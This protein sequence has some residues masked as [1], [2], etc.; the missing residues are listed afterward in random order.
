ME[1]DRPL[2]NIDPRSSNP[3]GEKKGNGNQQIEANRNLPNLITSLSEVVKVA[4]H[5][6]PPK[7]I[8]SLDDSVM[9]KPNPNTTIQEDKIWD[10]DPS[11]PHSSLV[12]HVSN[13]LMAGD[14]KGSKDKQVL[15][16]VSNHREP[17]SGFLSFCVK[18]VIHMDAERIKR[19]LRLT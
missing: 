1:E 15:M 9:L 5:N 16:G 4:K 2:K 11:N 12:N 18:A 17:F 14:E 10:P 13:V 19:S 6:V 3:E 8:T 7:L